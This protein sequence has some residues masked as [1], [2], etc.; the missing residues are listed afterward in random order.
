MANRLAALEARVAALESQNRLL[1]NVVASLLQQMPHELLGRVE[2][3]SY[4]ALAGG[5]ATLA[6][7]A[8]NLTE[9]YPTEELPDRTPA[10]R[11]MKRTE[12]IAPIDQP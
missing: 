1:T 6:N 11:P 9:P 8:I 2:I 3:E 10:E 7:L 4:I 5:A 12:T